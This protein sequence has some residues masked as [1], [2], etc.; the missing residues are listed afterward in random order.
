[1]LNGNSES[2]ESERTCKNK[3]ENAK[4]CK[5]MY[6]ISF[7]TKHLGYRHPKIGRKAQT[8]CEHKKYNMPGHRKLL[9]SVLASKTRLHPLKA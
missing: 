1:V 9:A 5:D 7:Q 6:N 2:E 8:I 4:I 3:Q